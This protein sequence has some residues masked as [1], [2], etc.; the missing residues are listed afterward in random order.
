MSL[1]WETLK[2][3]D[4]PDP[5]Y[6][7]LMMDKKVLGYGIRYG[8]DSFGSFAAVPLRD[9]EGTLYNLQKIYNAPLNGLNNKW[10]VSGARKSGVSMFLESL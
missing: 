7:Y 6:R 5:T 10:F 2:F 9:N 8:R 4:K 3:S 1:E